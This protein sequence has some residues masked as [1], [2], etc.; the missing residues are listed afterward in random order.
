MMG[1]IE[2]HIMRLV[3]HYPNLLTTKR[4]KNQV[5]S[6]SYLSYNAQFCVRWKEPSF[7]VYDVLVRRGEFIM[8]GLYSV[9]CINTW[10]GDKNYSIPQFAVMD[11][12]GNLVPVGSKFQHILDCRMAG[13]ISS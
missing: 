1:N 7:I 4:V 13:W 10:T 12:F 5:V 11:D 8:A 2:R 6:R 3:D 9:E